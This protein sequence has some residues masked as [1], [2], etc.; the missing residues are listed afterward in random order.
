MDKLKEIF[1]KQKNLQDKLNT[2]N[3]RSV[4]E[5]TAF[6]KEYSL[7]LVDEVHEML[8]EL[9]YLKPWSKKYDEWSQEK[10]DSQMQLARE[11][12]I[13]AFHFMMNL[14]IGLDM[15]P[16]MIHTMYMEKNKV[17]HKRQEEGY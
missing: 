17:N 13:D 6:I 3:F 14:A 16:E 15:T 10:I 8:R 2:C 4:Q 9:P 11:E 12:F 5:R 7:H 1:N